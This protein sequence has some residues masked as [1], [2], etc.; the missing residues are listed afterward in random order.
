MVLFS[1]LYFTADHVR[2]TRSK[3]SRS[4]FRMESEKASSFNICIPVGFL[5]T[6]TS[7]D[8]FVEAF[9]VTTVFICRSLISISLLQDVF[10]WHALFSVSVLIWIDGNPSHPRWCSRNNHTS[11]LYPLHGRPAALTLSCMD[12]PRMCWAV[13]GRVSKKDSRVLLS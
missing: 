12:F 10:K 4:Y 13:G 2:F 8:T 7:S 9:L 5:T 1:A 11:I 6:R 3:H